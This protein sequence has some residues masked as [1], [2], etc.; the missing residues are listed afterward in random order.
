[1]TALILI[2]SCETC[3]HFAPWRE[4]GLDY[5][6]DLPED[7]GVCNRITADYDELDPNENPDSKAHLMQQWS[8]LREGVEIDIPDAT[9]KA[10]GMPDKRA[11]HLCADKQEQWLTG[12]LPVNDAFLELTRDGMEGE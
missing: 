1:M 7:W 12:V 6:G 3:K 10:A 2:P 9:L 5:D 4:A 11:A 8:E